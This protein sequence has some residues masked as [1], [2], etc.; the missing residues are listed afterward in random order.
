MLSAK[1]NKKA[2]EKQLWVYENHVVELNTNDI[3][4]SKHTQSNTGAIFEFL[5]MKIVIYYLNLTHDE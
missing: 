3:T 5:Y 2:G 1:F 4:Y